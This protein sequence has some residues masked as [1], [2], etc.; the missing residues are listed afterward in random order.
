MANIGSF[1]A[2]MPGLWREETFWS[3]FSPGSEKKAE[4]IQRIKNERRVR[5][6][7]ENDR[8]LAVLRANVPADRLREQYK[9]DFLDGSREYPPIH[10]VFDLDGAENSVTALARY[11]YDD[12][13]GRALSL[14]FPNQRIKC[15]W[16]VDGLGDYGNFT[17]LNGEVL[18]NASGNINEDF[19]SA[20][21]EDYGCDI[22]GERVP[23]DD[24]NWLTSSVGLCNKCR[25]E[26]TQ[27]DANRIMD[28]EGDSVLISCI[29]KKYATE[30]QIV[31]NFYCVRKQR[32]PD[33]NPGNRPCPDTD[34]C[35]LCGNYAVPDGEE[36]RHDG[37]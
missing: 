3:L 25:D 1:T 23:Y 7:V 2:S 9:G 21:H 34:K 32:D 31:G 27:K 16:F 37:R 8:F 24:V 19:N 22:C 33:R 6:T 28:H 5:L 36:H 17:L 30:Q 29:L 15:S 14:L 20:A 12:R 10:V 35:H 11:T 18:N 13:L 4:L 26:M